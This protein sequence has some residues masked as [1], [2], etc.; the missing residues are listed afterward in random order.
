MDLL[1]MKESP[2][3]QLLHCL[4]N[5]CTGGE[6]EFADCFKAIDVLMQEHPEHAERLTRSIIIYGYENDGQFFIDEKPIIKLRKDDHEVTHLSIVGAH[7]RDWMSRVERVYWSPP[8]MKSIANAA[9]DGNTAAFLDASRAFAEILER[10]SMKYETKLPAGTCAV[11]DNLR[12]VHARKAFDMNSGKRWLKGV[13]GDHQDVW[14]KTK[15]YLG[16][17]N[18]A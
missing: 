5:S 7:N 14:S 17:G 13:Y 11:F 16:Q 3:L 9:H 12:V 18:R 4:E 15:R 8:F 1:Y 6:S 10:P 2:G